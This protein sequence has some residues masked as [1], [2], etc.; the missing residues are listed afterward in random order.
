MLRTLARV[1]LAFAIVAAVKTAVTA[2]ALVAA[3]AL[4]P[5]AGLSVLAGLPRLALAAHAQ[6]HVGTLAALLAVRTA[7]HTAC[8]LVT[9]LRGVKRAA[10]VPLLA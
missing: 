10:P 5:L 6:A 3:A 2:V 1:V 8:T 7:V 4:L 9:A